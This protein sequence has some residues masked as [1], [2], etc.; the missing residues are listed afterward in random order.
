MRQSV[1]LSMEQHFYEY[2]VSHIWIT[3]YDW[4]SS[5]VDLRHEQSVVEVYQN[6]QPLWITMMHSYMQLIVLKFVIRDIACG[7]LHSTWFGSNVEL[8]RQ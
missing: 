8:R 6:I 3:N 4:V 7:A 2:C 5:A 1:S